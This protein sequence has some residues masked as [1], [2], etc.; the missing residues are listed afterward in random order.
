M[1]EPR[2]ITLDRGWI[3]MLRDLGLDPLDALRRAVLPLDLIGKESARLTVHEYFRLLDATE[4]LAQ[5][6]LLALHIGEVAS[7]ET[8]S[9]P[10]FAALCS[11][12]LTVAVE[13]IATH[14]R[15]IA[16]MHVTHRETEAGL[17]VAWAWDDPTIQSP[18]LLVAMELILM[19]KI[20]RLG[21]R[22]PMRPV[23]VTAPVPLEPIEA[24]SEYFGT[25]PV[26]AAET[27]LTFSLA[28]AHR[29]FLTASDALWRSFEPELRRRIGKLDAAAPTSARTRSV[30]LECLPSGEA[31]LDG[32]ARRLGVSRRTLQRRLGEEGL[33]FRQVVQDTRE[34]LSRHYLMN[35]ALPYAEISFLVGFDEPSSFFRAFRDWTGATPESIRLRRAGLQ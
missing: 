15:L 23:R 4:Q 8:F 5:D 6:P 1:T 33:T 24:Y 18:R 13:R 22:E 2:D 27:S 14:K 32:I 9:P 28:D 19:T 17:V 35:T 29:P 30:L 31:T 21:T 3:I 16:P 34:R 25:E 20:A 11:S 7:A 12:T 10:I 26:L